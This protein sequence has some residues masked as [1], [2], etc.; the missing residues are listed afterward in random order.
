[1]NWGG[2]IV[3]SGGAVTGKKGF[4]KCPYR[5]AALEAGEKIYYNGTTCNR[6][7]VDGGRWTSTRCC[8]KCRVERY[9]EYKERDPEYL[10]KMRM[11][12]EIK[13]IWDPNYRKKKHRKFYDKLLADEEK[14]EASR[15]SRRNH[16]HEKIKTDPIRAQK[17]RESVRRSRVG[18]SSH[19]RG[20]SMYR[21]AE[22]LKRI[23][24]WANMEEVREFY[25]NRPDGYHVDHDIPL[26]GKH[27]SGLH[28]VDNLRYLPIS[29]NCK[30]SN[31][32]DIDVFSAA[33]TIRIRKLL[34]G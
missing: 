30:K 7:H 22:G 13:L 16:Y 12:E 10:D 33:E 20:A 6:G 2:G 29:D 32:F 15:G 11:A 17:H 34:Y 21:R 23:P 25:K 26:C 1:M 19:Y 5:A 4:Q 24:P 8:V 14:I 18:K 3:N 28:V 31:K 27:V 9:K